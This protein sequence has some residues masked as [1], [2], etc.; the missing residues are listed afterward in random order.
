M[1]ELLKKIVEFF[2]NNETAR[3]L[4]IGSLGAVVG[5]VFLDFTKKRLLKT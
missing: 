4:L 2:K 1:P 3:D 5:A